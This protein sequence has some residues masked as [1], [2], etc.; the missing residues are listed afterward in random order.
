M[1]ILLLADSHLGIDLPSRPRVE[2]RRRGHD[3]LANYALALAPAL[4][5]EVDLV[6]HAGDVFDRPTVVPTLAYQAFEPLRRIAERGVPVFIV[7]G[8]HE[9]S[10]LP[11]VRFAA[12][13]RIHIFDRP[14]TF[15]VHVRDHTIALAG[16]PYERHDVRHRFPELLDASE[17]NAATATH[18][19]LCMHH[20]VEG[21]TVGPSDYRFTT[22]DDVVRH[23]DFPPG[24]AA[25]LTG[26]IHRH[27]VLTTDL[28]GRALRVPV[29]YPGSIE[30]TALA[31]I[32]EVKGYMMVQ[33]PVESG[34][35]PRWEFRALPARPMRRDELSADALAPDALDAAIRTLVAAA[36]SDCVLA[37]RVSGTLSDAHWQVMS[38][39]HL[40]AFVPATMNV[41][42]VPAGRVFTPYRRERTAPS[43]DQQ[44]SL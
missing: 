30:R 16:F 26:H 19:L 37:I 18:R 39:T 31:E 40:R 1:R 9:R 4:A 8:N 41:E 21:A 35:R 38:S 6:V 2:R 34:A 32:G 23:S 28:A 7:P 17:W 36:P 29:L 13:P 44:L 14:R 11:H 24:F 42:V 22:A 12:H 20:C 5:G 3:F 25:V 15:T 33:L 43:V 10:R 27:Q